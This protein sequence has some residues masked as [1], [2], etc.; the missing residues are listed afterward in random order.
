MVDVLN[1]IQTILDADWTSGNTDSLTPTVSDI[2]ELK[3]LDMANNDYVLLYEVNEGVSPLGIG[4][5]T[6]THNNVVSMDIRTTFKKAVQGNIRAH[7]VKMKDEVER[8]M[9]AN[10]SIPD[11][12]FLLL[13]IVRLRDLSNKSIGVG[14]M[15]MDV[16]LDRYDT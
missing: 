15:V 4:G 8:I 14:R 16:Q 1:T 11:A 5:S 6:W 13:K 12:T 2:V 10:T 3:Y 7:L 9:K